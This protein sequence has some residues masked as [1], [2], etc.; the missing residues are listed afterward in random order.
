MAG[1]ITIE[2]GKR[3]HSMVAVRD[4]ASYAVAALDNHHSHQQ[5]LYIGGRKVLLV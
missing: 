3:W 4:V 1:V 5:T 2:D